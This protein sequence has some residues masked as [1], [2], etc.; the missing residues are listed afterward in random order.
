MIGRMMLGCGCQSRSG[1]SGRGAQAAEQRRRPVCD[2]RFAVAQQTD[3]LVDVGGP[4]R[5]DAFQRSHGKFNDFFRW[6][7]DGPR[8]MDG[9]F[10]GRGLH[11]TKPF[12]GSRANRRVTRLQ[13][14]HT[15]G[16]FFV[17]N[18]VR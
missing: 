14:R 10:L 5:T 8:E 13:I 9:R 12:R 18:I 15:L 11:P 6:I 2:V 4:W 3:Q 7:D 16:N 1:G 17:H